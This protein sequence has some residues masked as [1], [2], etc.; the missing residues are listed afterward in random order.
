MTTFTDFTTS[1]GDDLSDTDDEALP[2]SIRLVYFFC[3][4]VVTPD[5][6]ECNMPTNAIQVNKKFRK[7]EVQY[8]DCIKMI[9][10]KIGTQTCYV[11]QHT[12]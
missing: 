3:V 9:R 11:H 7:F 2:Q 4:C 1:V 8:R 6:L 10:D 5:S 12:F